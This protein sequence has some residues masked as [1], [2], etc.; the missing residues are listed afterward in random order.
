MKFLIFFLTLCVSIQARNDFKNTIFV[1]TSRNRTPGFFS[2]FEGVL[3]FLDFYE[4]HPCAGVSVNFENQGYYYDSSHGPNWW[5]YYFEPINIVHNNKG[6]TRYLDWDSMHLLS[7]KTYTLMSRWRAHELISRYVKIKP[8]ITTRVQDFTQQNFDGSFIIGI[9]YRGTDKNLEA[10]RVSYQKVYDEIEKI[11]CHIPHYKIFVATDEQAF[12]DDIVK[13]YDTIIYY[14]VIRSRSEC[15]VHVMPGNGYIKGEQALIDCLILSR[16]N[17]IIRT[18]SYLS[19]CA[20]FFNPFVPIITLNM[21][22]KNDYITLL[23]EPKI[24]ARYALV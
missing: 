4:T 17:L 14:P 9:H 11:T 2:N 3:G 23:S 22:Y 21:L 5:E 24:L 10:D 20:G 1:F 6:F 18:E 8:A 16:C 19:H 12:L 15:A 13:K 7:L